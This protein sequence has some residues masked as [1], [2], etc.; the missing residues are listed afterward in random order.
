MAI[1]EQQRE[2]RRKY[3]GSSDAAAVMGVDPYKSAADLWLDKTGQCDGFDGNDATDRGNWLEPA[4]LNFAEHRLSAALRVHGAFIRD[5]MKV[6]D[7]QLLSANFD[8][9]QAVGGVNEEPFIVE[10]KSSVI[11]ANWGEDGT[12]QVPDH[13]LI[14]VHHQ[15]FVAGPEYRVAYVPVILPA[16][17]SFD[18]RLFRVERNNDLAE[19]VAQRGMEFMRKY[20]QP[21]IMPSNYKPSLEVLK[22]MRREP[23]KVVP[24][25]DSLVDSL[26]IARATR[27]QA[28]ADVKQAETELLEA[29]GDADGASYCGGVVTYLETHRKGYT[30][31][32]TTFRSLK[33]KAAK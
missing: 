32:P 3:I 18:F 2:Q 25:N 31:E 22:R 30:V 11:D 5:L 8:G 14:Q 4:L 29:M 21:R 15:F 19:L 16:F 13:V 28:E 26:I 27:K 23:Q 7:S 24:V 20:V 33:V 12:D 17:K 1:S 6:H 10:A 9:I